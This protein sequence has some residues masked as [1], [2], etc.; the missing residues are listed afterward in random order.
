M[1]RM[2]H[3]SKNGDVSGKNALFSS[4]K[5]ANVYLSHQDVEQRSLPRPRRTDNRQDLTGLH[6][7]ADSFENV[8]HP[9][10]TAHDR[11]LCLRH[12][13]TEPNV[14]EPQL[15]LVPSFGAEVK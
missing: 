2:L 12:S 13:H 6:G 10:R 3:L 7:S 5:Q 1:P 4:A 8:F 14:T 11:S 9:R 15:Y